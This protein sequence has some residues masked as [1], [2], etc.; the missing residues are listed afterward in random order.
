MGTID[1]L[2]PTTY[3]PPSPGQVLSKRRSLNTI[4]EDDE[5]SN[6]GSMIEVYRRR[7]RSP[8]MADWLSPLS[9]HFPTPRGN[10]FMSAPIP[11]SSTGSDVESRSPSPSA[12]APSSAPWTRNSYS[13]DA[14]EFDD[15]YDA[16]S[17]EDTRRKNSN[18]Q[19]RRANRLSTGSNTSR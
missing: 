9:D 15:L 16:F 7:D 10:H 5:E 13:T 12:S 1:F 2:P 3:R 18:R 14:T 19:S 6:R 11:P 4:M 8:K 17:D